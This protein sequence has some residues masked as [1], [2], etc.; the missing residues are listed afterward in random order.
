MK[1]QK[2]KSITIVAVLYVTIVIALGNPG[3]VLAQENASVH[4]VIISDFKFTPEVLTVNPGDTVI[5][6]N[7]DIVPHTA[8]ATDK[9]WDTGFIGSNESNEMVI[10][11]SQTLSYYCLYHPNMTATLALE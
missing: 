10:K 1:N 11:H 2:I 9:S 4:T 8:T 5:W 3:V 7:Q 6:I